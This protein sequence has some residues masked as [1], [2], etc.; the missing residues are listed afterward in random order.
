MVSSKWRFLA[1]ILQKILL[2]NLVN[3]RCHLKKMSCLFFTEV[4]TQMCKKD[5]WSIKYFIK[6]EIVIPFITDPYYIK[7]KK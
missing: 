1:V 3:N 5:F 2:E 6:G 4:Y 7:K